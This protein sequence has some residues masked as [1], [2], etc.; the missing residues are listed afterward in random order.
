MP[1]VAIAQGTRHYY[2][3]PYPSDRQT[4]P[5]CGGPKGRVGVRCQQCHLKRAGAQRKL[6]ARARRMAL[7]WMEA[8]QRG[9]T[10]YWV[11]ISQDDDVD[12]LQV[13]K[14]VIYGEQSISSCS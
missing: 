3:L 2:Y 11:L 7:A 9:E 10:P 1:D 6:R 4:C 5:D 14:E 12:F 13:I 8:R